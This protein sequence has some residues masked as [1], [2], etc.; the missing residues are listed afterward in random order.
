MCIRHVLI[1]S[2]AATMF[3]LAAA[4]QAASDTRQQSE[5]WP[6]RVLVTNDNGIHDSKVW[7]LARAFA[8]HSDT[9]LVAANQ[10]RSGTSNQISLG[11]DK[12][13]ITVQRVFK[14]KRLTAYAVP[15][16]PADCVIF[17]LLGPLRDAPPD[18]VVSGVNGG[19]NVGVRG[20]FGSGTIGAA[21][22]AAMFGIPAIAVSGL[23][24]DDQKMVAKVTQ[25]IVK[26]A[27]SSIVRNLEPGQYLTVAIPRI[28]ADE[29]RGIRIATR[30]P[31]TDHLYGF[32]RVQK[33]KDG[34]ERWEVWV[35]RP[36]GR[37]PDVPDGSDVAFYRQGYIVITPMRI[38]EVDQA[39]IPVLRKH[40]NELPAWSGNG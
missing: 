39:E 26:L 19:P 16:Y 17:G 18:L 28:R 15:G 34:G 10:D 1:V 27:G 7:A 20:W 30:A 23:E 21:R 24:D 40:L 12:Q 3:C 33:L 37:M 13:A 14:D 8:R 32:R 4:S 38:G 29:I 6:Q 22:T 35:A 2:L 31:V 9:W 5:G 36:T 11:K 25:W